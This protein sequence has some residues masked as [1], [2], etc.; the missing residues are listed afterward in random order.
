MFMKVL[1]DLEKELATQTILNVGSITVSIGIA[2]W[3]ESS[4]DISEV[5]KIA[6]KYLYEAKQWKELCKVLINS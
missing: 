3:P 6:D 2:S 5:F 1:S 4:E